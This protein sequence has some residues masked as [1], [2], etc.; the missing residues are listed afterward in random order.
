MTMDAAPM[1]KRKGAEAP[2]PW[3]DGVPVPATK[4]RRL[5]RA[6]LA[7]ALPCLSLCSQCV[8]IWLLTPAFVA[9]AQDAVVPPVKP[10]TAVVQPVELAGA[11]V[12]PQPLEVA[13]VVVALAANDERA[14]VVY[15]LAEAT[16]SLLRGPLRPIAP[17]VLIL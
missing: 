14:I 4:I 2:E 13:P 9:I 11:G 3:L 15:Q 1:L 12:P 17:L 16:R 10:G 5:V 7:I 8:S 6:H